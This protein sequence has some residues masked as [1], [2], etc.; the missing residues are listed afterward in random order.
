M[1]SKKINI[2]AGAVIKLQYVGEQKPC[3][4]IIALSIAPIVGTTD[5]VG[6]IEMLYAMDADT[7]Q[8]LQTNSKSDVC[9]HIIVATAEERAEYYE[10]LL[11]YVTGRPYTRNTGEDVKP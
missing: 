7:H 9:V 1:M 4:T 8:F 2:A 10:R 6:C 11:A 5:R 3:D